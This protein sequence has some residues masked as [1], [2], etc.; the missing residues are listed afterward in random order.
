MQMIGK[1]STV[2]QALAR[3]PDLADQ[4]RPLLQA[5]QSVRQYG[6]SAISKD[7]VKRG[8]ERLMT[9]AASLRER[10]KGWKRIPSFLRFAFL[11]LLVMGLLTLGGNG[12]LK[13]SAH[14]LPGDALYGVKRTAE[15]IQLTLAFNTSQR[16][17]LQ[18]QFDQ[19]RIEETESLLAGKRTEQVEFSGP[20]EARLPDGWLVSGLR[21]IL[22]SQTAVNGKIAIGAQVEVTGLT[23]I[24]GDILA[25]RIR[26]AAGEEGSGDPG[27]ATT[28]EDNE[29]LLPTATQ[30][31][32]L[33]GFLP[34]PSATGSYQGNDH[35][36]EAC[37]TQEG[38]PTQWEP[39]GTR[40]PRPGRT[41]D[42]EL[43]PPPTGTSAPGETPWPTPT[44]GSTHDD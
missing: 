28:G 12:L 33:P 3:F 34:T 36:Q 32:T 6:Q 23:Q 7:V 31:S 21:V 30:E 18:D 8:R 14:S 27:A 1:G 15:N 16:T 11:V 37:S 38:N 19:L 20:V 5:A 43:T 17:V 41:P 29:G 39:E 24:N 10:E 35:C 4:L 42:S 25:V 26:T 44:S 13:A 9:H 2:N 40:T 22:N